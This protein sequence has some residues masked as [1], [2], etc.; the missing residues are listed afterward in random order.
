MGQAIDIHVAQNGR[1]V[2]PRSVRETLGIVDGG[3]VVL[4]TEGDEVKL[5]PMSQSIRRAQNLYRQYARTDASA[6]DFIAERRAEAAHEDKDK[7]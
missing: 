6:D 4:S 2:L 7:A 5:I 3:V 1:L